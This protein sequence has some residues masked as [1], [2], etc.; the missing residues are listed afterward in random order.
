MCAEPVSRP[1]RQRV[2][3]YAVI[4]R[5]GRILLSRLA[6]YLSA[7]ERWTLPGGGIDFGEHP[8][9]ALVREVHEETG[10]SATV[11]RP[12]LVDSERKHA[13]I[14]DTD[15]HSVRL[16][17]DATVAADAP[18]PHVVEVDGS[19]VDAAWHAVDDVL[20]GKVATVPMV[21]LALAR[22]R[23]VR[24]QRVAAYVL[25]VR[26]DRV[27]LTRHSPRGPRPGR[28][29]LPGGGVDHGEPPA[30]A[31]AR[32]V[33]EETG[34]EA[35]VGALLGIHDEHFTGV[36]PDGTEED[37]HGIALVF[38]GEV[39]AGDPAVGEVGGTT[40]EAR[41]TLLTDLHGTEVSPV[42][43]AALAMGPAR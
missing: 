15:M 4:L 19:T 37:F 8:D 25:A 3:A 28:W 14:S 33:R 32:E 43:T 39:G 16:V 35:R 36:A 9:D 7:T 20:S 23:T 10:L 17:Y 12:L 41:W 30:S 6:P 22:H 13:T 26:D 5:E 24:R 29:S 34:L 1:R 21:R 42:V 38:A 2:A 18:E 11:G 31:A 27:L 40:D